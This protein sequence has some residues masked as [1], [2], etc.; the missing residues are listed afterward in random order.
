M[1][2]LIS[3]VV[4]SSLF[5]NGFYAQS[6]KEEDYYDFSNLNKLEKV[7]FPYT[8]KR[9]SVFT[10]LLNKKKLLKGLSDSDSKI[11]V[12][13]DILK[14]E[15][16]LKGIQSEKETLK[17]QFIRNNPSSFIAP[18][19]LKSLLITRE[20]ETLYDSIF[21]LYKNMNETVRNSPDGKEMEILFTRMNQ[22][23]PGSLAPDFNARD[24]SGKQLSLSS[25][26]NSEYILPDFWASWCV[27]F[28]EDFSFLKDSYQKYHSKGLEIIDISEH[29]D[30]RAWKKSIDHDKVDIWKHILSQKKR[31]E[32]IN[33]HILEVIL[34]MQFL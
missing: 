23:K 28:R 26:W 27:P 17:L 15:D 4:L 5:F 7:N 10:L 21:V 31:I 32:Q 9:H 25:F 30:S 13:R 33:N 14:L 16:V 18:G 29:K 2:H 6:L 24:I 22:S 8:L 34:F 19:R 1:K 20:D 3:I 11:K 12:R